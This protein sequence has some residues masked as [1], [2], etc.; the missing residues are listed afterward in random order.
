MK[1]T[2]KH[3]LNVMVFFSDP[4]IFVLLRIISFQSS[5]Y[6]SFCGLYAVHSTTQALLW[7]LSEVG[8]FIIPSAVLEEGTTLAAP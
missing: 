6:L 8:H 4:H 7:L 5:I 1:V 3:Y 2:F